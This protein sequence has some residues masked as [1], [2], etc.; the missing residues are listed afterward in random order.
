VVVVDEAVGDSV[1]VVV[2]VVEVVVVDVIVVVVEVVVV[3]VVVVVVEEMIDSV[4]VG[5]DVPEDCSDV[6]FV[7]DVAIWV[8]VPVEATLLQTKGCLRVG[9]VHFTSFH[10]PSFMMKN[11]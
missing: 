5:G 11:L 9:S 2:V 4:V 3:D 10:L 8:V 7:E 1:V 6:G